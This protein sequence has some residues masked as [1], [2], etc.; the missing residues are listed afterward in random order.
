M[1]VG[2]SLKLEINFLATSTK[3]AMLWLF[4]DQ[5][6]E[7]KEIKDDDLLLCKE[8]N[9]VI[10]FKFCNDV[11]GFVNVPQ[12]WPKAT[13]SHSSSLRPGIMQTRLCWACHKISCLLV[14]FNKQ[15]G[16]TCSAASEK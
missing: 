9:I 16:K 11:F 7:R 3:Q 1:S 2:I 8:K 6:A 12:I 10:S 15:F 13:L 14:D 5:K 4:L